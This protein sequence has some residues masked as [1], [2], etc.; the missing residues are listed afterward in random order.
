VTPIVLKRPLAE[1]DLLAH[2]TYIGDRNPDA[3]DRFFDAAE[4]A[5]SRLARF[6]RMGR[7]WDSS[8]SR[9][10]DLRSWT[11]P[12]F[13][14]YRIFYRPVDG[15]IEVVRVLHAKRNIRRLLE[16]EDAGD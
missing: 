7:A 11:I 8:S 6:P 1:R 3:A 9:L 12:Q 5:L 2:Y 15:G 10:V 16:E 13:R 14:N 4:E